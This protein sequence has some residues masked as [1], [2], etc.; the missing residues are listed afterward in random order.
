M[1]KR[2][3]I[4]TGIQA[5]R[6]LRRAKF[7]LLL[8]L[9]LF[10]ATMSNA[11][12][13]AQA[14]SSATPE[15]VK[16]AVAEF[17]K[18]AQQT[19][20]K[21]GVPGLAVAVVYDDR[22][23]ELKGFGVRQVGKPETVD[24][25]TVFQLA[26]V[27][28]AVTSTVL[29]R[30]VGEGVIQWDDLVINH[31]AGFQMYDPW[32]TRQL[33]LR[34]LLC[35]RSGLPDHAGDLVEDLG[36]DQAEV[37]HRLRYLKPASSFRSA[38]AY[39]NFGYTEA[40]V[41]AAMS[42]GKACDTLAA[43]KLY[44]PLGMKETSSQY[45]DYLISKNRAVIH[46]RIDGKWVAKFNRNADAQSPAG[47]VSS[48]VRDMAQWLRLQLADG[49]FDGKQLI[50]ADALRETHRPQMISSPA[51]DPDIDRTG[52]YGL[53]WNVNVDDH[54]R[55]RMN[56]SGGFDMGA[57]TVVF[58]VP[59]EKLGVVV[60]TNASP[61]GVPEAIGATFCDLAIDGKPQQEWFELYRHG[62]EEISKPNYGTDVDYGKPPVKKLPPL[63]NSAYVGRYGNKY[64]G[65]IEV[66]EKDGALELRMGP[67]KSAYPLA[68]WDRD[69]FTYQPAGEMSAGLSGVTFTIGPGQ[70]ATQLM[71]ENLDVYGEGTFIKAATDK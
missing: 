18:L 1:M 26:S 66:A 54:G 22:V 9:V 56:H 29:A 45:Q 15:S 31:D 5:A 47:G 11:A 62:F 63:A 14:E 2:C 68:H 60:L 8:W 36:Y 25:D 28:K 6:L 51:K 7:F 33:T 42:A 46:A 67:K 59:S 43:E 4:D 48:S 3:A 40:A 71:I 50:A 10:R 49:K 57:A 27:S 53:G 23:V 21:T 30:L 69:V 12:E 13:A 32:V 65:E 55:V 19:L 37:L 44:R 24:A 20:D 16:S 58:L 64:F 41:A 38:F 61:I 39:T 35:H 52:F 34:D 70:A 17:E